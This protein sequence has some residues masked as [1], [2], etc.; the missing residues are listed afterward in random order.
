MGLSAG[1]LSTSWTD[2]SASLT[3]GESDTRRLF[4]TG[5]LWPLDMLSAVAA[6]LAVCGITNG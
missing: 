4:A 5:A 3:V 1:G 6:R 2:E